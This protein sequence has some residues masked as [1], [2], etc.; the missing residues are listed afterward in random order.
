MDLQLA[1]LFP[2]LDLNIP[3]NTPS[4]AV[5][6]FIQLFKLNSD[7]R[8][9]KGGFIKLYKASILVKG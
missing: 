9:K 4:P 6:C 7:H 5:L 2:K 1:V 3:M 8:R